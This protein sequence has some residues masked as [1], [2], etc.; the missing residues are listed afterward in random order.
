MSADRVVCRTPT[1]GKQAKHIERW[2]YDSVRKAILSILPR[3]G[4]GVRFDSLPR[5]IDAKLTK[6]ERAD[7]GSVN[8][9]TATVKLDL[10]V[11]REIARV[12]GS[13]PQ[14]LLRLK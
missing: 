11:R 2:K 9:Y 6:Q 4:E 14:R 1:P 7:L 3:T 12:K 10:E 8:W 5:L 13:S